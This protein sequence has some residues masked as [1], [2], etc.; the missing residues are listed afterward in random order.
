MRYGRDA[1]GRGML[2][3][4][5]YQ[6]EDSYSDGE[7]EEEILAFVSNRKDLEEVIAQD[8]R[9][10]ILY[11]LSPERRNLLEWFPFRSDATLLEVGAGCGALTGLFCERV[12]RVVAVELSRRRARITAERYRDTSNL[13]I[14]VGNLEDI[15]FSES[16]DYI[17]LIG[18][19]EYT[20]SFI[21]TKDP[22]GRLFDILLPRLR[23]DGMVVIAIENRF[24]LKY[25]AG[26]A[27]DHTGHLF[28]AISTPALGKRIET[29]SRQG[30][31]SL[32][33]RNGL[34]DFHF[35]YPHP[36]YKLPK[37]IF[38]DAYLPGPASLLDEAPCYD[39]AGL[40]L[41]DERLG[42]FHLV[43]EGMY[44]WFANSFLVLAKRGE[45]R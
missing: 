34:C 3:L 24:G 9:W 37:E 26:A 20:R 6:G 5:H 2:N 27:D 43:R 13:E 28:E 11:H 25:W 36:D 4:N 31:I 21:G 33:R 10:P 12:K 44:P 30:L 7:I 18:V 16:F 29:F 15:P 14:I 1:R 42:F 32:L 41:F 40:R 19:L 17:T 35:Y 23:E 22:Y 39:H 8:N 38:S 45:E